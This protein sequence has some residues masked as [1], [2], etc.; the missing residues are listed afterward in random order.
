[1]S[2]LSSSLRALRCFYSF[3]WCRRE[4]DEAEQIMFNANGLRGGCFD[5]LGPYAGPVTGITP[6]AVCIP[7]KK[8]GFLSFG[9]WTPSLQSQA[10]TAADALLPSIDL[11]V[12]AEELGADGAYF[13]V[14]HFT[15]QLA[16]PFPLLAAAGEPH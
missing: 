15:R 9:H 6:L 8:I 13:R 3:F 7:M 16:S 14:H 4:F 12:A 5:Q 1:M 10:R 2:I 11:A